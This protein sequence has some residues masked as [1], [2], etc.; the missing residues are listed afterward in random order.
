MPVFNE[1]ATVEK[2]VQAVLAQP[3]VAELV[4]VDDASTDG[5]GEILKRLAEHEARIK[6]FQHPVNQG[7]GAAVR[8]G[9]ANVTAA[10]VIVQDAEITIE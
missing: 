8:T 5:T 6:V 3:Q 7:K 9:F 10:L 4:C 2:S 1:A